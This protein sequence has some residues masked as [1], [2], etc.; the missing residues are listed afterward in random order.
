M[1]I[2]AQ[3]HSTAKRAV[4]IVGFALVLA[5][6]LIG[7]G[8]L[9]ADRESGP[10]AQAL[11]VA[12]AAYI[13]PVVNLRIA[14]ATAESAWSAALASTLTARTEVHVANGRVDVLSDHYA[15]EVDRL[16]KWHEGIG[17]AAHY[18]QVTGKTACLAIIIDSDL[19][20]LNEATISK[21]RTIEQTA[22]STGVK[23]LI[24]RRL[25]PVASEEGSP[26]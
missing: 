23:L 25:P 3:V 8:K 10:S 7:L 16:D 14:D 22:I 26:K 24:L 21:L 20:P 6:A 5:G 2:E 11:P 12:N 13:A 19:W 15:I 9:S 4:L 18:S 17:Q 1:P